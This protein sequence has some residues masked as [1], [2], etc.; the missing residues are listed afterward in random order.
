MQFSTYD[1]DNDDWSDVNCATNY[2]NGGNWYRYCA[3]QNMNGK[4]G[5][6]GDA[7]GDYMFWLYFDTIK[8]NM[9]LKTMRWMVREVV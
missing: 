6:D 7:G 3:L 5:V 9:A 8:S 4:Y 2:G 1:V